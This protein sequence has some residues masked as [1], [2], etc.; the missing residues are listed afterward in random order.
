[1]TAC[2]AGK[3]KGGTMSSILET[4]Y[5]STAAD[6]SL[7]LS[8]TIAPT[9]ASKLWVRSN[10]DNSKRMTLGYFE[11]PI[12]PK[13]LADILATVDAPDFTGL[14]NPAS[15]VPGEVV[16]KITVK[17]ST[18]PA[19]IKFVGEGAPA[20]AAFATGESAFARAIEESYKLPAIAIE[21]GIDALPAE[22]KWGEE[23][24]LD[25]Q[26]SNPGRQALR[27][28]VP[29][30]WSDA[31]TELSGKGIR[32]DIPLA[33]LNN[34]HAPTVAIGPGNIGSAAP[35]SPDGRIQLGP[36]KSIRIP[37][38]IRMAWEPGPYDFQITFE[39]NLVDALGKTHTRFE[40]ISPKSKLVVKQP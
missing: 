9:G 10:R 16:R 4:E 32:T 34:S 21:I 1:M 14:S 18:G 23:M 5:W 25:F 20:P 6:E 24:R 26:L 2:Q 19:M 37:I 38:Q 22:V 28:A 31:G 30:A 39:S 36:G 3:E 27:I 12:A 15:V 33:K 29:K 40:W 35:T 17:K 7:P 8:L 11:G 13:S